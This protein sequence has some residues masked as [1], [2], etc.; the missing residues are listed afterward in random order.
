MII[1][2]YNSNLYIGNYSNY[3]RCFIGCEV[4]P[5]LFDILLKKNHIT[6]I[7][8][9]ITFTDAALSSMLS[10]SDHPS[11]FNSVITTRSKSN[12]KLLSFYPSEKF[13]KLLVI[14]K[15]MRNFSF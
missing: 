5:Y 6:D 9:P 15:K 3:L 7:R 4:P 14:L 10:D 8:I 12:K 1:L 13:C 11:H 2:F